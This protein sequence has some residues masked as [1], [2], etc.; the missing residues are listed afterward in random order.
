MTTHLPLSD[1]LQRHVLTLDS[2]YGARMSSDG[3]FLRL[4]RCL[5][6]PGYGRVSAEVLIDLP[7]DYF[8]CPPGFGSSRIHLPSTLRFHK[9]RLLHL[10]PEVTP[11]WGDWAWF[12][13]VL[14]D[15]DSEY[16]DLVKFLKKLY[17]VLIYPETRAEC[18]S[19]PTSSKQRPT[20]TG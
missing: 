10:Y 1:V 7:P 14:R 13:F 20:R 3:H 19:T 12:S 6:P 16:D 4:Y 17:A 8:L 5:L 15:W 11:G 9:C 18:S 2:S